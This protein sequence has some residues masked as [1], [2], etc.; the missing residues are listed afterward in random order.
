MNQSDRIA[1]D[2][3]EGC[4]A[5]RATAAVILNDARADSDNLPQLVRALREAA[6]NANSDDDGIRGHG[7]GVLF[8]V[9]EAII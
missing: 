3:S 1:K 2:Y 5:G 7:I 9:A 8:A 4:A 6:T